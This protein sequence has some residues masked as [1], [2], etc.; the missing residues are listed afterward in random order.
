MDITVER[1]A[2]MQFDIKV[3]NHLNKSSF[4]WRSWECSVF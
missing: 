2:A 1:L 3:R 4:C